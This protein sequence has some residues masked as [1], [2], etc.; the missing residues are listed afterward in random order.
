[1]RYLRKMPFTAL[2]CAVLVLFLLLPNTM[3]DWAMF[4]SNLNHDGTAAGE[5]IYNPTLLWNYSTGGS[6]DSSPAI[7]GGVVY[8]SSTDG[9]TYALNALTGKQTWN[10][11]NPS[12][13]SC[14]PAVSDGVVYVTAQNGYT[15]PFLALNAT[16]GNKIWSSPVG[17]GYSASPIVYNGL[18]Y[19]GQRQSQYPN[20]FALDCHDGKQVWGFQMGDIECAPAIANGILYIGSRDGNVYALNAADGSQI[21]KFYSNLAFTPTPF[22]TSPAVANGIIYIAISGSN[23]DTNG[24]ANTFFAL[25]ATNGKKIWSYVSTESSSYFISSPAVSNGLVYDCSRNG[26]VYAFNAVNG[27][28]VWKTLAGSWML[29]SPA[30]VKNVIY[31]ASGDGYLLALDTSTGNKIWSYPSDERAIDG[32]SSPAFDNGVIYIGSTDHR[33]YA[34]TGTTNPT[35]SPTITPTPT[36]PTQTP[37]PTLTPSPTSNQTSTPTPKPTQPTSVNATTDKGKIFALPISGNIT[38]SQMTN[39]TL[40]ND[41]TSTRLSFTLTGQNGNTG[42]GNVTIPKSAVNIG[43]APIVFIDG[44][45]ASNQGYTQDVDNYYVWFT[46]HFSSHEMAIVFSAPAVTPAFPF[47]LNVTWLTILFVV[48]IVSL[49]AVLPVAILFIKK[50]KTEM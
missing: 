41:E 34:I 18:V 3:A 5:P 30:V 17:D 11:S 50:R 38:C 19:I 10:Y 22:V 35:S 8:V 45:P 15:D 46:T 2:T 16:N 44:Q 31:L 14:S 6:V 32:T 47:E 37:Q 43:T 27:A 7:V 40:S 23:S 25:N 13:T 21:W 24:V 9:Y 26:Y 12:S 39:V 33:I 48:V 49:I 36:S 42:F 4:R 28:L 29:S 20:L 1:M